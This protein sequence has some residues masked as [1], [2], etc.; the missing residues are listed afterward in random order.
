MKERIKTLWK[1]PL[2]KVGIGLGSVAF[3][4]SCCLIISAL[5]PP[6]TP[7]S[8]GLSAEDIQNTAL[9]SAWDSFTQTAA[10]LPTNTPQPTNT[11]TPEL[12]ATPSNTPAPT[13]TPAPTVDPLF[14]AKI[15]G[16]YLVNVDIAP[17]VWKSNGSGDSCYW[18]V[19]TANGDILANHFGMA[20]GTAY[21]SPE[22]FQV[23]FQDCGTWVFIQ[24]P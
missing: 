14:D 12:S 8:P 22:A 11:A 3:L 21:V 19:T 7:T 15:S 23:Q 2:G 20:G 17:G 9:A 13:D 1:T 10:A 16:F 4:C 18:S 6:T 5:L 24:G